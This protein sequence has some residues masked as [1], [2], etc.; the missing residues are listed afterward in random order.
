MKTRQVNSSTGFEHTDAFGRDHAHS[1]VDT[2]RLEP[3]T[4]E[5]EKREIQKLIAR[6]GKT[7]DMKTGSY[8]LV[9]GL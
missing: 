3:L 8:V 9:P 2:R 4:V 6:R 7:W 1:G 5:Q